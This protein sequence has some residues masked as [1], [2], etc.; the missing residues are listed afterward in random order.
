MSNNSTPLSAY[1]GVWVWIQI[2][3]EEFYPPSLELL[4]VGRTVAD[5]LH[6]ELVAV[7]TGGGTEAHA[8]NL[9]GFESDRI[10]GVEHPMLKSFNTDA[11][12]KVLAELVMQRKPSVVL[13]SA[14]LE[15]RDLASVVAAR[16]CSGL[17]ADCTSLEVNNKGQLVQIRPDFGGKS[18]SAIL[19][20]K[21]RP[22]MATI[23]P[24]AYPRPSPNKS[25]QVTLEVVRPD[26]SSADVRVR[27]V[28]LEKRTANETD[29]SRSDTIV[30]V[31]MGLRSKDNLH[32]AYKLAEVLKGSVG[33]TL[34][35]VERGWL[36][37]SLQIGQTGR[38][39]APRLYIAV[40][41]SGAVQ[42]TVGME[43]SE[44]IIAINSDRESRIF[45][46]ADVGIV[47][48][49]FEI[50]PAL[51]ARL[52]EYREGKIGAGEIT[53]LKASLPLHDPS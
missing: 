37:S 8:R 44:F 5:S 36:P 53:S 26:L 34:A 22:Q 31:G 16:T 35:V 3:E 41:V 47:G 30:A 6:E 42:H 20:P 13:Y 4:T 32:F 17:A 9:S 40:G 51:T 14:S 19:T 39:V 21:S 23:R 38:I 12:G 28:R 11:H 1:K 25:R 15:G 18:L 2:L 50:L 10:I 45:T 24:G 46:T 49:L 27:H 43:G 52:K 7:I 48:D 33:G 29:V